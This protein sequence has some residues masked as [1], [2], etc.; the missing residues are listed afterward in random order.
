MAPSWATHLAD[1]EWS[2]PRNP[3]VE[4]A[5]RPD[6]T[7]HR[8]TETGRNREAW[9]LSDAVIFRPA[10]VSGVNVSWPVLPSAAMRSTQRCAR[11]SPDQLGVASP[12]RAAAAAAS[13]RLLTPSLDRI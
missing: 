4:T 13:P 3:G 8:R 11:F 5:N 9:G 7:L 1:T 2:I 6:G 12:S 10:P